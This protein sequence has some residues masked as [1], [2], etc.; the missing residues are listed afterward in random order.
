MHSQS[1]WHC[2]NIKQNSVLIYHWVILLYLNLAQHQKCN[3]SSNKKLCINNILEIN[4]LSVN[5]TFQMLQ[6]CLTL[7]AQPHTWQISLDEPLTNSC[8]ISSRTWM[9]LFFN[10][11]TPYGIGLSVTVINPDGSRTAQRHWVVT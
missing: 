5:S 9:L 3:G 8:V 4:V 7:T 10:P 11:S 6:R 1:L 2:I